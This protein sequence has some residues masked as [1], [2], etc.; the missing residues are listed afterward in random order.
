MLTVLQGCSWLP[1]YA[2]LTDDKLAFTKMVDSNE[3]LD[4]V[5]LHEIAEVGRARLQ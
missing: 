2:V 4:Y 3:V 5:P 1:R